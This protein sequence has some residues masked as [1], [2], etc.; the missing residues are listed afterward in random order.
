[1]PTLIRFHRTGD[2]AVLQYDNVPAQKLQ[3]GEVRL[4]VEAIGLNRAEVMFREGRYVEEPEFPSLLGYE[5]AGVIE[6]VGPGVEDIK[7]G[8][9]AASIPAF[10]MKRYG[11]YGD[12]VVLPA[13]AMAKTPDGLSSVEAAACRSQ[14]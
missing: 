12:S 3:T 9:R 7:P 5:A 11:T 8:D 4:K 1:M 2:P 13:A 10:S 14:K 6:E